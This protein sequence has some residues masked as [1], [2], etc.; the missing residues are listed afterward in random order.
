MNV[1]PPLDDRPPIPGV[2]QAGGPE[3]VVED[4]V[5]EVDSGP[6]QAPMLSAMESRILTIL[7]EERH[8]SFAVLR[9]RIGA[10]AD[11]L[12]SALD[13]LRAQGLVTR[14]NTLGESY[15]SRF[16]GLSVDH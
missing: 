5:I 7:S 11:E 14:L 12:R 2:E 10:P 16:P 8:L 9:T 13:G 1:T 15:A 6:V 4:L 3:Q